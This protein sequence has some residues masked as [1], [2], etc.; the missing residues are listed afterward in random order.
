MSPR[1]NLDAETAKDVIRLIF[2]L[3]DPRYNPAAGLRTTRN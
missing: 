1:G 3:T 2:D